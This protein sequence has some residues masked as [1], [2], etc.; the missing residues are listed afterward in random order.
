M[1]GYWRRKTYVAAA[2][3]P[4]KTEKSQRGTRETNPQTKNQ[5]SP[6]RRRGETMEKQNSKWRK[7]QK[8]P[9][10]SIEEVV[11]RERVGEGAIR[12]R[13]YHQTKSSGEKGHPSRET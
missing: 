11:G 1:L 8:H 5:S 12:K 2:R 7:G 10:A 9:E 4:A 6:M 3:G 13:D